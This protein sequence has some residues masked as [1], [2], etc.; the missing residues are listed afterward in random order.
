MSHTHP[1]QNEGTTALRELSRSARADMRQP[2]CWFHACL[3]HCVLNCLLIMICNKILRKGRPKDHSP[4]PQLIKQTHNRKRT[5]PL[6]NL[7]A[8]PPTDSEMWTCI[9]D[10]IA[11]VD[12][13]LLRTQPMWERQGSE[14][15][16]ILKQYK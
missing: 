9:M 14:E 7:K 4:E 3:V 11:S 16:Q 5:S 2:G 12:A 10:Q 13:S 1:L 8:L 15:N 6:G